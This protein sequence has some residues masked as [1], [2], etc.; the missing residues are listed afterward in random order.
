MSPKSGI[1]LFHFISPTPPSR[2]GDCLAKSSTRG[3]SPI[4]A[5]IFSRASSGFFAVGF[6]RGNDKLMDICRLPFGMA[7][8]ASRQISAFPLV[9]EA[10]GHK[11]NC[12]PFIL[13]QP[14]KGN[15]LI[16]EAP[17][18]YEPQGLSWG[19]VAHKKS[20]LSGAARS[21]TG[22]AHSSSIPIVG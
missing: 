19:K 7:L 8:V 6:N 11:T 2:A 13:F 4:R 21:A 22:S 16:A 9:Q 1:V 18:L 17:R 20:A 3:R 5:T 15:R 14:D 12:P 10:K